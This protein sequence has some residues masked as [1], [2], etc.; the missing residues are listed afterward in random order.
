NYMGRAYPSTK[1]QLEAKGFTL[2]QKEVVTNRFD[3]NR[4][5]SQDVVA[6]QVVVPRLTTIT[7]TIAK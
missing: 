5:I 6:G 1:R 2:T 3:N 4:I 7:F